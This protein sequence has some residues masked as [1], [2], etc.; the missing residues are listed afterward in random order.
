MVSAAHILV[1]TLGYGILSGAGSEIGKA[2]T[3]K[4]KK[5]VRQWLRKL[6]KPKRARKKPR[7]TK[8]AIH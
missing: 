2:A 4:I 7:S 3:K 6:N 8:R 5:Y 1:V